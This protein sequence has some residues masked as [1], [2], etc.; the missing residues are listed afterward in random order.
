MR[1]IPV[2]ASRATQTTVMSVVVRISQTVVDD[3]VTVR[4]SF[5]SS[6]PAAPSLTDHVTTPHRDDAT[7]GHRLHRASVIRRRRRT[8]RESRTRTR[9]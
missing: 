7:V 4:R 6:S 3:D 5:K 2:A 8:R 9:S 1:Y